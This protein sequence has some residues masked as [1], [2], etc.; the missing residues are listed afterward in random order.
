MDAILFLCVLCYLCLGAGCN[1]WNIICRKQFEV[2]LVCFQ[3]L[4]IVDKAAINIYVLSIFVGV[5]FHFFWVNTKEPG[6]WIIW[7][8]S[9]IRNSQTVFQSNCT[10][11]H[12]YEAVNEH[13]FCSTSSPVFGG[14]SVL[15]FDHSNRCLVVSDCYFNSQLT[16]ELEH[17]TC[18]LHILFS[19]VSF[20]IIFDWIVHFLIIIKTELSRILRV[21]YVFRIAV[22]HQMY[23]LQVFPPSLC[24][25]ILL[26]VSF[27][28]QRF[29][30]FIKSFFSIFFHGLLVDCV[31][32]E[33]FSTVYSVPL[34]SP[35]SMLHCIDY[36]SF[37]LS[38]EVR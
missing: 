13:F 10:I 38:P 22:L 9:F 34:S 1:I 2:H 8:F 7:Y 36:C 33:L 3:V 21:L 20:L 35:L 4:A 29:L 37:I 32:V 5:S 31:Y 12:S 16:Y 25:L 23:L 19:E 14:I 28:E 27:T 15:N 11:L 26:T 24:F 17:I 30:I 18:H 6:Y